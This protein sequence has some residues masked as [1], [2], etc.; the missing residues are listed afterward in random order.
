[1]RS[2]PR[3]WSSGSTRSRSSSSSCDA[4]GPPPEME[5]VLLGIDTATRR[6]SIALAGPATSA[7]RRLPEG[8]WH[9]RSLLPAIETLLDAAGLSKEDLGGIG[10][11]GG[12][13]SLTGVR[14]GLETAERSGFAL[15]IPVVGMSTLE[16][17]AR[18]GAPGIGA[19]AK[20]V[21][22]VIEAGR[23]EIYGAVFSVAPTG[24]V[25]ID[26]DAAWRPEDLA[27]RLAPGTVVSGDGTATLR[28]A[29]A[30]VETVETP[31]LAPAIAAQ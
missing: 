7:L 25:R 4:P 6:P 1:M 20:A 13:G 8:A 3:S 23:G 27:R 24:I 15:G 18:A 5:R 11:A 22:P 10:V 17:M 28:A 31:A 14:S 16:A 30:R 19:A 26:A 9:A 12:P 29:G 2:E 21:C